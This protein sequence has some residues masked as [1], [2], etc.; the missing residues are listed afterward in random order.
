VPIAEDAFWEQVRAAVAATDD[1]LP[2]M[3][4]P[5][6]HVEEWSLVTVDDLADVRKRVP[7]GA[8]V[9]LC[10]SPLWDCTNGRLDELMATAHQLVD[11]D[12]RLRCVWREAATGR[13]YSDLPVYDHVGLFD[14]RATIA[15]ADRFAAY[16]CS[17]G[18][19]WPEGVIAA[20]T[21]DV[22]GVLE[23]RWRLMV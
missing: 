16:P 1:P 12:R 17:P 18:T 3:W 23:S 15:D 8:M 7:P 5:A 19:E 10:A 22:D 2:L 14:R 4:Q 21:P 20:Q 11:E 13:I 6:M 9:L